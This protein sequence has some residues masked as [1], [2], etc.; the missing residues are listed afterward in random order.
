MS[1]APIVIHAE[2]DLRE[3]PAVVA[4]VQQLSEALQ[5]AAGIAWPIQLTFWDPGAIG[6][7]P[8]GVVLLSLM[9]DAERGDEAF[10]E[11]EARWRS[12]IEALTAEGAPVLALTL[13]RAVGERTSASG[14]QLLE[15]IRRLDRMTLDLSHAFGLTVV[16][17]DRAFAHIG[18]RTL[19]T[20]YQLGGRL[21]AEVG[22]HALTLCLLTLGLDDTIP[23]EVQE[24]ARAFHGPLREIDTLV[25][26]R[27]AA[28]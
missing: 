22:G 9:A 24:R 2:V 7:P 17:V 19:G 1:V 8:G 12:R 27:L 26:R 5:A 23:P 3:R 6:E 25:R 13:F 14:Q 15:R 28:G 21:A 16:D 10:G 20:D 11:V 4:A 18:A